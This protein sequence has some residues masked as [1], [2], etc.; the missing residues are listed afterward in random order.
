[1]AHY[2]GLLTSPLVPKLWQ[3]FSFVFLTER[4]GVCMAKF[5][6]SVVKGPHPML[7][8]HVHVDTDTAPTR[9]RVNKNADVRRKNI[10]QQFETVWTAKGNVP[11]TLFPTKKVWT[12]FKERN[13][14]DLKLYELALNQNCSTP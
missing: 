10:T 8:A 2:T 4:M 5:F 11:Q 14:L 6:Q 9:A 12:S 13:E 3:R 1:M 7:P